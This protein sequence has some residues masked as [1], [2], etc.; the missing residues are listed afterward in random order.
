MESKENSLLDMS[1]SLLDRSSLNELS[2]SNIQV[3]MIPGTQYVTITMNDE[4][5]KLFT[6]NVKVIENDKILE[7]SVYGSLIGQNGTF[8][9]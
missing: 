7:N 5:G 2:K 6:K 3:Y 9:N 1:A 4:N 8:M